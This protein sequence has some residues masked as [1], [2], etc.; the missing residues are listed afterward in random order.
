MRRGNAVANTNHKRRFI[1][2]EN[3]YKRLANV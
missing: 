1:S 3:I 2:F